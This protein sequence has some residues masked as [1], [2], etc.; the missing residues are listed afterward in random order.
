MVRLAWFGLGATL[1]FFNLRL[2]APS[3]LPQTRNEVPAGILAQLTS[4]RTALGSDAPQKMQSLFPEGFYFSHLLYGLTWIEVA[5]RDPSHRERALEEAKWVHDKLCSPEGM[6]PFPAS[7]PPDH[8][9]F[10]SAWKCHLQAGIVTIDRDNEA[11][12]NQLREECDAISSGFTNARTPFLPSYVGSAWP[13]DSVPAIHALR[14]YDRITGENR[15]Q[16]VIATWL[17]EAKQRV[18][19]DTG[20]LPHMASLPDG[21]IVSEARGTSQM[22]M[23]RLLPDIDPAF[24][25]EQ[26]AA[27]RPRFLNRFLEIPTVRE[28][29]TG[30][31]GVGDVDSGPLIFGNSLSSTVMMVGVAQIYGDSTLANSMAQVGETIGLPWTS[32]GRKFYMCGALPLG[33]AIVSY[34]YIARSWFSDRDHVPATREALNRWWR[35][36][37][38][39]LSTIWFVPFLPALYR[40]R[41]QKDNRKHL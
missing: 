33:D 6:A 39:A 16:Q 30:V 3:P 5:I 13:C 23:L 1:L 38:H 34:S 10:Y 32:K 9:M 40:L 18:D 20:L 35:W 2:Y 37:V 17:V 27:F 41:K 12:L 15:Y 25:A 21:R 8:G 31:D 7:L 26:Y 14:T 29:P 11:E 28:Y 22:V 19:R 24:A 4:S 36:K